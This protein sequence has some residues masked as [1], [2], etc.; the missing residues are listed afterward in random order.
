MSECVLAMGEGRAWMRERL[1]A[2][3]LGWLAR[4]GELV[5]RRMLERVAALTGHGSEEWT[6]CFA[7]SAGRGA[8]LTSEAPRVAPIGGRAEGLE[9]ALAECGYW[10]R[11]RRRGEYY[12]WRALVFQRLLRLAARHGRRTPGRL[13][14]EYV[15]EEG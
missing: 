12:R 14:K 7:G 9:E 6:W 11:R 1:T 13:L 3:G 8:L 4:D 15:E 5:N 10:L 2:G